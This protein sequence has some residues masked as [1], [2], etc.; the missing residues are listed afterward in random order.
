MVSCGFLISLNC[1]DHFPVDPAIAPTV[2]HQLVTLCRSIC[3]EESPQILD[4]LMGSKC[5]TTYFMAFVV[6]LFSLYFLFT[7]LDAVLQHL[8][9]GS[10]PLSPHAVDTSDTSANESEASHPRR[11][12][13]SNRTFKMNKVWE[14]D[15]VGRFFVTEATAAAGKPCQFCCRI[16]R[17]HVSVLTNG[18]HEVLRQF[19]GAKYFARDQRLRLETPGWRVLD[20][21]GNPLTAGVSWSA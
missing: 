15:E 17:K 11:R 2:G 19:Q 5:L 14:A 10:A 4:P 7:E 12:V 20:F 9:H 6:F 16:C 18:P 1:L 13:R 21:E 3:A 8:G